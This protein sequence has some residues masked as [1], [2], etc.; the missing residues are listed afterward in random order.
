[1]FPFALSPSIPTINTSINGENVVEA[2]ARN[3]QLHVEDLA[4]PHL[5]AVDETSA[6]RAIYNLILR[7][8]NERYRARARP[9][10]LDNDKYQWIGAHSHLSLFKKD[11]GITLYVYRY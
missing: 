1:M 2:F 5:T 10:N 6:A 3:A 8:A 4:T 7:S 9:L 11:F